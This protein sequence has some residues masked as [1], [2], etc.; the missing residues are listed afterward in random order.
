MPSCNCNGQC[1]KPPYTCNG[2][3]GPALQPI[4]IHIVCNGTCRESPYICDCS[5]MPGKQV[6]YTEEQR[7]KIYDDYHKLPNGHPDKPFSPSWVA[8]S[9]RQQSNFNGWPKIAAE[10]RKNLMEKS[11]SNPNQGLAIFS[12]SLYKV[13]TTRP[14]DLLTL[15][16]KY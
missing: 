16:K 11:L 7:A 10:F 14:N 9:M 3:S 6:Q 1:K 12:T 2:G 8:E 15:S 5:F 13:Q 4:N